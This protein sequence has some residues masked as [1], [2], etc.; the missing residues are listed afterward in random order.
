M[1]SWQN[2]T[3]IPQSLTTN[4]L[5]VTNRLGPRSTLYRAPNEADISFKPPHGFG[6]SQQRAKS[7][8]KKKSEPG[9]QDRD[10]KATWAPGIPGSHDMPEHV[11]AVAWFPDPGR[12]DSRP[13]QGDHTVN[14]WLKP[15]R[16]LAEPAEP[17]TAVFFVFFH[18]RPHSSASRLLFVHR[19]NAARLNRWAPVATQAVKSWKTKC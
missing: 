4:Y 17:A 16:R 2:P 14:S 1:S 11:T 6:K 10:R 8:A 9:G 12:H 18:V 15:S 13:S 7:W 3:H 5:P 19:K